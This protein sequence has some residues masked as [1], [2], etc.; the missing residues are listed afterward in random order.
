MKSK[1]KTVLIKNISYKQKSLDKNMSQKKQKSGLKL[2]VK[3]QVSFGTMAEHKKS[4]S[5][6]PKPTLKG[7]NK[8]S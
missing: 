3:N 8:K 5:Y 2:K 4:A 1:S 6:V 7:V